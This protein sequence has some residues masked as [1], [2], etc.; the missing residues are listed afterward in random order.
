MKEFI[1]IGEI[2]KLMNVSTH[3]IRYFEEKKILVP[4]YIDENGYRMY[5]VDEI[6]TLSH[7]L[8]L[9]KVNI[10]VSDIKICFSEFSKSDYQSMLTQS[11]KNMDEQINNLIDL[12]DATKKIINESN[13]HMEILN[14]FQVNII[15]ER[16][17]H[18]FAQIDINSYLNA[19][20]MYHKMHNV[21]NGTN[22]FEQD[23]INL[24]DDKYNYLCMEVKRNSHKV[25]THTLIEGN[26]LCYHFV[27]SDESSFKITVNEFFAYAKTQSLTLSGK[28]IVIE[29]SMLSIFY[30]DRL[31]FQLQMLIRV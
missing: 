17:L 29:N 22:L 13:S 7:I 20:E 12:R 27:A 25:I 10:S 4:K 8:L 24:Y 15:K 19:K 26:Y 16:Y 30:K 9:R 14:K 21:S 28:L 5:G 1:T 18:Q 6:Y 3:Q 11:V 23:M 31:H 2:A